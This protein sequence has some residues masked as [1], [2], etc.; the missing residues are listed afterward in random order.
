MH[1]G[2]NRY[3]CSNTVL[4]LKKLRTSLKDYQITDPKIT[5]NKVTDDSV[6]QVPWSNGSV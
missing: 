4:F 2:Y 6:N 5:I 1:E 3:Y